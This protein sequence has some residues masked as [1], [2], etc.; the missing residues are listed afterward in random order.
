MPNPFTPETDQAPAQSAQTDYAGQWR[1]WLSDPGNRAALMQFGISLM[2]PIAPGQTPIG[3]FGSALGS[4]GEAISRR[5]KQDLAEAEVGS[6]AQL[7]E[8]AAQLAETRANAAVQ[9]I[10]HQSEVLDLKRMLGLMERSTKLQ[11]AY[12]KAKRDAELLGGKPLSIEEF[13]RQNRQL[14]MLEAGGQPGAGAQGTSAATPPKVGDVVRGYRF[15]GGKPSDPNSW[16]K[17]Q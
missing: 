12:Q 2:Q 16:E 13:I 3:H 6:K 4:A 17:V 15:K 7:R 9:N 10:G 11:E 1:G 8:S 14:M 5:E